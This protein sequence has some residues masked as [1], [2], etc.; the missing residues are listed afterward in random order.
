[1]NPSNPIDHS[2]TSPSALSIRHPEQV[3]PVLVNI[4][5]GLIQPPPETVNNCRPNS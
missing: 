3:P 1:M 2:T 5:P 4:D